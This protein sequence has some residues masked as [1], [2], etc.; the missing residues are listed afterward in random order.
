MYLLCFLTLPLQVQ[1]LE[2]GGKAHL[3]AVRH[4]GYIRVQPYGPRQPYIN[5]KIALQFYANMLGVR[6]VLWHQ[7]EADNLINT[8]TS[9][10]CQRFTVCN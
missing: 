9:R 10:L 8:P 5:L 4:M 2:T 3:K 7:G 1:L 6:A